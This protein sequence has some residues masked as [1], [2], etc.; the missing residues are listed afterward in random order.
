M[1]IFLVQ[2][3]TQES[4]ISAK[5]RPLGSPQVPLVTCVRLS[6]VACVNS[7]QLAAHLTNGSSV[8]I[9]LPGSIVCA[10]VFPGK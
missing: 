7:H 5:E 1:F 6:Q 2:E 4:R 9:V 10:Q 8:A 3:E